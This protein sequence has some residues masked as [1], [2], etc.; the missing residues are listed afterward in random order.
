MRQVFY[1]A[2]K[3]KFF[4]GGQPTLIPRPETEELVDLVIRSEA[5]PPLRFLEVGPGS[6][7][8]SLALL[9]AWP[10]AQAEAVEVRAHAVALTRETL[11]MLTHADVCGRMRTYAD[12][13]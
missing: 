1:A 12:A 13:C 2:V 8:I 4:F 5:T 6:G 3:H 10:H 9:K 7:A 11:Y